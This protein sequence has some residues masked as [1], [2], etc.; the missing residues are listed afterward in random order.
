MSRFVHVGHLSSIGV[1]VGQYVER[2]DYIG[3]VGS[4][5]ASTGSHLHI[6]GHREKP[7]NFR[8]YVRG[9]SLKQVEAKYFDVRPY[10]DDAKAIP[11]KIDFPTI[12]YGFLQFVKERAI[13]PF[14]GYWHPGVDANGV[15]DYGAPIKAILPG[16]VVFL[17]DVSWV[18]NK[19]GRLLGTDY[20]GGWGRHIFIEVDEAKCKQLNLK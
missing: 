8:A 12:G 15:N 4:S 14:G 6:E 7:A 2:G 19:L 1:K 17:E 18:K 20:N 5:G 10:F 9:M 3:K 13:R 11:I 16:R